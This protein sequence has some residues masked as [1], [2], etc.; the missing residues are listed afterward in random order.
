V[1]R[2]GDPAGAADLDHPLD[3][4]RACDTVRAWPVTQSG[5]LVRCAHDAIAE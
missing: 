2:Q 5:V 1:G 4:L 3:R